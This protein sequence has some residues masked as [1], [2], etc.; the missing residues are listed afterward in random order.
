MSPQFAKSSDLNKAIKTQ[1]IDVGLVTTLTENSTC[2][3]Y[4]IKAVEVKY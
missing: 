4:Y 2:T 1:G 3:V